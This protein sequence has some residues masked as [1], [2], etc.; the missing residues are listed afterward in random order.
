MFVP[1]VQGCRAQGDKRRLGRQRSVP[2][3]TLAAR[4]RGGGDAQTRAGKLLVE[5]YALMREGN[6][7]IHV[8]RLKKLRR[9]PLGLGEWLRG[10]R[11]EGRA[12]S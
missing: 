11:G 12:A 3:C 9:Q 1:Q 7:H 4:R 2:A 5:L 10:A 8:L 6:D